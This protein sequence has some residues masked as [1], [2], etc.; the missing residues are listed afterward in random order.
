MPPLSSDARVRHRLLTLE[1][2]SG[3]PR[4]GLLVHVR[5]DFSTFGPEVG[6]LRRVLRLMK[7]APF[8][9]LE[10]PAPRGRS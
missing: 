8:R 7:C 5:F 6:I 10:T 1:R 9:Q 4:R 2:A 3:A